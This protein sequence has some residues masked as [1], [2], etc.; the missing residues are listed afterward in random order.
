MP[1]ASWNPVAQVEWIDDPDADRS[2]LVFLQPLEFPHEGLDE[3]PLTDIERAG[4][5]RR[6]P[7]G[8][9]S[10]CRLDAGPMRDAAEW[11]ETYRRYWEDQLEAT[12]NS[13]Y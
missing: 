1:L 6:S 8:R 11:V 4:L 5:V 2:R 9:I 7:D 12:F 10:R 13:R 3:V